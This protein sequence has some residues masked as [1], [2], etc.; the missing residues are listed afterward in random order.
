M[1]R[2]IHTTAMAVVAVAAGAVL[3]PMAG[4][5]EAARDAV[6]GKPA[7]GPERTMN[8]L[9]QQPAAWTASQDAP[10]TGAC[11]NRGTARRPGGPSGPCTVAP[12]TT[13]EKQKLLMLLA[14]WRAMS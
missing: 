14:L 12:A 8:R 1:N 7:T 5:G 11:G 10:Q 13:T 9:A 4:T 3:L 6:G 2:L